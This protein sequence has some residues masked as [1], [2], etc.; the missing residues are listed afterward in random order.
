MTLGDDVEEFAV[1]DGAEMRGV[2]QHSGT[3]V[4]HFGLRA[5][6]LPCFTVTLGT[7]VE[8]DGKDLFRGDSGVERQRILDEFGFRRDGP[9]VAGKGGISKIGGEEKENDE[10]NGGGAR[11]FRL[12]GIVHHLNFPTHW[13]V[14]AQGGLGSGT[15]G[16]PEE[17]G[18]EDEDGGHPRHDCGGRREP[19]EGDRD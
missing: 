11:R 10:E 6:S 14:A 9:N 17:F 1:G 18:V 16:Q 4:V 13:M 3:R 2:G 15:K 7:F 19:N 12:L 8:I 5:I